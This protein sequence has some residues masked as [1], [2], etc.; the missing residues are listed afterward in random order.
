MAK[1]EPFIH[2]QKWA[3]KKRGVRY[4][5]SPLPFVTKQDAVGPSWIDF[6]HILCF[7]SFLMYLDNSI[8]YTC[9]ELLCRCESPH[10][11]E[12]VNCLLT[13]STQPQAYVASELIMLTPVPPPCYLTISHSGNCAQADHIPFDTCSLI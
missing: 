2:N 11:M 4:I 9:P 13:M 6:V 12:D 10:Q 5:F 3:S 8:Q 1:Y 7:S